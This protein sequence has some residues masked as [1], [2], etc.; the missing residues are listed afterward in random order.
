MRFA[1]LLAL[2]AAFLLAGCG[3]P[4]PTPAQV[5]ERFF[6]MCAA[7]KYAEIYEGTTVA[8]RVEKTAK[9]FEARVRDMQFDRVTEL[10]WQDPVIKDD[11]AQRWCE[12]TIPSG[13]KLTIIITMHR[14]GKTWRIHE[15]KRVDS[16]VRHDLFAVRSRSTDTLESAS[17]SFTEPVTM[18]PPTERLVRKMIEKT[19]LDFNEAI[20]AKAFDEFYTTISDRWKFRGM[21][22]REINEDIENKRGRITVPMLNTAFKPFIDAGVDISGI[23]KSE[24]K[25]FEPPRI[26]SDGVLL[27]EGQ[28]ALPKTRV[29]FKLEYY[30]E[31]GLWRLFGLSVDLKP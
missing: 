26:N 15:I 30:F 3:V 9:Y 27:A 4:P 18:E 7:K 16:E 31:G 10:K 20:K 1:S 12:V 6:E 11:I 13:E 14:D 17:K 2:I 23:T 21:T 8:F 19:L 29:L 28:F 24:M 5:S 25:L 22:Q